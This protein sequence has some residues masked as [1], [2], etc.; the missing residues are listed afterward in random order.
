VQSAVSDISG[1]GVQNSK[2]ISGGAFAVLDVYTGGRRRGQLR[3]A[4]A[5]VSQAAARA[6][7]VVDGVAYEV[8]YA[9]TAVDDAR[10][11]VAEAR[12]AVAHARENFRMV[13]NRYQ[14]GDAQPTDVIEAQ[15]SQ[16]RA[17]QQYNGTIYEYQT[18]VARLE[19]AVGSPIAGPAAPAEEVPVP[20]PTT[21]TSPGARP[22]TQPPDTRPPSRK[23]RPPIKIPPLP[24]PQGP[25]L[26]RTLTPP[27]AGQPTSPGPSSPPSATP[28]LAR[29]PYAA[30]PAGRGP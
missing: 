24:S 28:G 13:N 16:T 5:S 9:H 22:E 19:F 4:Q 10:E 1:V 17:E 20:V 14:T 15:T 21:T 27:P 11:R 23:A 25:D 6:K 7:Q 2:V 3:A 26:F 30:P 8:H 18:A 29:P 12:T